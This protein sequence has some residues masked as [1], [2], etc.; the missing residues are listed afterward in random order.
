MKPI[1]NPK[2]HVT[3]P[4]VPQNKVANKPF[5]TP[6]TTPSPLNS[7]A[8]TVFGQITQESDQN[9]QRSWLV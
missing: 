8:K 3:K 4:P 6:P 9:K 7:V 2:P 5:T 1:H